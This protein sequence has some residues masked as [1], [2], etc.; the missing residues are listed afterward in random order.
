MK[1]KELKNFRA[2][3]VKELEKSIKEKDVELIEMKASMSV[4][5]AKNLKKV[6]ML[7][8]EIS[9]IATVLREKALIEKDRKE[10]ER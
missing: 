7:R 4:A 6:K 9:Q 2:K 1:K 8:R 10:E 3:E 5:K